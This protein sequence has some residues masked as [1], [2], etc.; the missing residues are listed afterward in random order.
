MG[1]FEKS[2]GG[3]E[4][5]VRASRAVAVVCGCMGSGSAR[6]D[7]T[8]GSHRMLE[9]ESEHGGEL[10]TERMQLVADTCN[11]TLGSAGRRAWM[12]TS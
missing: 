2:V 3:S 12:P 10:C 11:V 4:P 5:A 7:D 6:R 9:E 8:G 1:Q